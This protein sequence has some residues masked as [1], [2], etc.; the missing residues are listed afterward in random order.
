MDGGGDM[1]AVFP[2]LGYKQH[3]ERWGGS[4]STPDWGA[5]EGLLGIPVDEV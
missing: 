2:W 5:E 4:V 3:P 1:H